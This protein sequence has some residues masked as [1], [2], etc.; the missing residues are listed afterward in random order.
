MSAREGYP[1]IAHD[2]EK[3]KTDC[4]E[5]LAALKQ[6]AS[7]LESR[8]RV[9]KTYDGIPLASIARAAIAKAMGAK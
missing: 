8:V 7:H 6:I 5:L 9:V 4:A 1:G 2:F 3:C